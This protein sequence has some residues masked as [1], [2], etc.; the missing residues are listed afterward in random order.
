MLYR[1]RGRKRFSDV[2]RSVAEEDRA[3]RL[4]DESTTRSRNGSICFK[5][6]ANRRYLCGTSTGSLCESNVFVHL[7]VALPM[8]CDM[9][10]RRSGVYPHHILAV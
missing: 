7:A 2:E 10:R 4:G 1:G 8:I 9:D 3:P 5:F 6:K